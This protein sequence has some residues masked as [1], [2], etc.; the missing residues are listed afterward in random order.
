MRDKLNKALHEKAKHLSN[1]Y[2]V[3]ENVAYIIMCTG[4]TTQQDFD[5]EKNLLDMADK[6]LK[7]KV[8]K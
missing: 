7:S 1:V 6:E 5:I 8:N 3:R 4:I 2:G